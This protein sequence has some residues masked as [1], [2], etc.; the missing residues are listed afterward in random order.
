MVSKADLV[1]LRRELHAHPEPG[2][3][4][5]RT[6]AIVARELDALGFDLAYGADALDADARYGVLD[7][8]SITAAIDRAR[9]ND[10]PGEYLDRIGRVTGLVAERTF[11]DGTGP[12]VGVRFD[13]DALE[14]QEADADDHH[15]TSEGF[16]S[17]EPGLMHA[18]GHDGHTT[19]GI[20]LA[21][22][23]DENGGFD[24]TLRLFA[25]PA[26]EGV[27][28]GYAMSQ[29][30]YLEDVDYFLA[31]HLGLETPTDTVITGMR[32]F[33]ASTKFDA[34]FR[35]QTAHAGAQPQN[36]KNALMAAAVAT[37][38]L[39]A[40]PRHEDGRTRV[41]VG[42]LD[43]EGARNAIPDHVEMALEVRGE[44]T[45]INEYMEE[46]AHRVLD[47]AGEMY[48]VEVETE[49]A[50]KAI[51]ETPSEGF[52]EAVADVLEDAGTHDTVEVE[53]RLGGSEDATFLMRR[54]KR[55][56]GLAT[57]V[58]VGA[59]IPSGHHTSRFDFDEDALPK[60]VAGL[61]AVVR[62][63]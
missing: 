49:I 33:L 50:G 15:P 10:A 61:A 13:L 6:T 1:D 56:G 7:D 57:Y 23:L 60:G 4:E 44:Q 55:E 29:T 22:E 38:N 59:D 9:R 2:W 46:R 17:R 24:G 14:I 26:E 19:I 41:N 21:R 18:C 62:A 54:V 48:D 32:G 34:T 51:A 5:F 11:G 36:G 63:L 12:V 20:G 16:A 8:A 25:Q 27:R 45:A 35:G 31:L 37:Q 47:A 39:L 30:N 53:G 52:A 43:A 58:N 40:I 3:E 28:G 42:R